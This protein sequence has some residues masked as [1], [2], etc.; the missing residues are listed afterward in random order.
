MVVAWRL[1][2][3][4]YAA[5]AFSAEGAEKY[6]GRWNSRGVAVVYAS[7]TLSLAALECLV[8]LTPPVTF[9][10]AA[11]RI[12]IPAKLVEKVRVGGLPRD[13]RGEPPGPASM[14]VGDRWVAGGSSAVLEVPSAI[15]PG[16][17]NYL[18]NPAHPGFDSIS[19]GRPEP[20]AF[21]RRLLSG[22]R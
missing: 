17:F 6:G 12:A 5:K 4:R 14:A 15:V 16:E 3:E 10:Y 19:V 18:L 22:R 8:H 7:A 21:D 11:F 13:W 9:R 20:F 1:V 2:R